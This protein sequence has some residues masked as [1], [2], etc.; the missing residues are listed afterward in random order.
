MGSRQESL[1]P[2]WAAA[3]SQARL[4]WV[5][6]H[7]GTSDPQNIITR[8][9]YRPF[10]IQ[11]SQHSFHELPQAFVFEKGMD[12]VQTTSPGAQSCPLAKCHLMHGQHVALKCLMELPEMG[13][14]GEEMQEMSKE[15]GKKTSLH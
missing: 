10:F 7:Q 9:F 1:Q 8:P 3:Q 13:R 6:P 14:T 2:L 12:H 11:R 15:G 4:S 5:L